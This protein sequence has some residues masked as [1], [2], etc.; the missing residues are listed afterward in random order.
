MATCCITHGT[1]GRIFLI[2]SQ[3]FSTLQELLQYYTRQA[4]LPQM[5]HYL[6]ASYQPAEC[7]I[8]HLARDYGMHTSLSSRASHNL[9]RS[10]G[11]PKLRNGSAPELLDDKCRYSGWIRKQGGGHKNCEY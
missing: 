6:W 5:E 8:P 7:Q 10:S 2:K 4:Y 9:L 3:L 1:Q 11:M